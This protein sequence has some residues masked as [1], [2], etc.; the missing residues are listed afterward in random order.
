MM[1]FAQTQEALEII[2]FINNARHIEEVQAASD[3][4]AEWMEVNDFLP[5]T[6][7]GLYCGA[8]DVAVQRAMNRLYSR[9]A[10]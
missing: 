1:S 9:T 10:C 2:N 5:N 3:Y 4:W 6:K 7:V 8:K